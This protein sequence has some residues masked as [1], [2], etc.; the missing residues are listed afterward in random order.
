M[1]AQKDAEIDCTQSAL[2]Q[3]IKSVR[4]NYN[5]AATFQIHSVNVISYVFVYVQQFQLET[6]NRT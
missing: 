1:N 4:K 3:T 2:L 6:T 5:G